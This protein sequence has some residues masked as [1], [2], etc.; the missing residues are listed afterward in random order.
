M[1]TKFPGSSPQTRSSSHVLPFE[2]H[3]FLFVTRM[4][5]CTERDFR[6]TLV[7][8]R[9]AEEAKAMSNQKSSQSSKHTRRKRSA[10]RNEA[11]SMESSQSPPSASSVAEAARQKMVAEAA[12]YRAQKRGFVPGRELDDWFEAEAEISAYFLEQEPAAAELH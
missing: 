12:Y 9:T 1:S 3:G 8:D 6:R 11:A 7:L 2:D 4:S 10:A 5:R